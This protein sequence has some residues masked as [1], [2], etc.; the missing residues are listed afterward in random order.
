MMPHRLPI[1]VETNG[2]VT[3]MF[4]IE[5]VTIQDSAPW[6][7]LPDPDYPWDVST[8]EEYPNDHETWVDGHGNP[9]DVP[10]WIG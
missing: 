1:E 4:E 9:T 2:G 3:L 7:G 10:E 5:N 6:Y 8:E